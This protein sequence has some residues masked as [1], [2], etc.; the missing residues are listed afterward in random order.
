MAK[1]G[2]PVNTNDVRETVAKIFEIK[3]SDHKPGKKWMKLFLQRYPE[4]TKRLSEIISKTRAS[5]TEPLI[6]KWF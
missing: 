1:I 3:S 4:I 2:Y 6:W 5:V